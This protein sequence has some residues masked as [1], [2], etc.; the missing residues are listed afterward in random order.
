MM[1]ASVSVH[2]G[3]PRHDGSGETSLHAPVIATPLFLK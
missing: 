2:S 3:T 1:T